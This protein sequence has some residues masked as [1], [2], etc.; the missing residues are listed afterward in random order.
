MTTSIHTLTNDEQQLL[1]MASTQIETFNAGDVIKAK[2]LF[3]QNFWMTQGR[4]VCTQIGVE[5]KRLAELN[6]LPL[7]FIGTD[8][9]N[10]CRYRVCTP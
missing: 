2:N 1:N 6:L 10:H 5:I 9:S 7:E 8:G 4:G 3:K